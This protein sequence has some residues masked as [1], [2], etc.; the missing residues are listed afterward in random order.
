MST[1][2]C[3]LIWPDGPPTISLMDHVYQLVY[4]L[5]TYLLPLLGLSVTYTYLGRVLWRMQWQRNYLLEN[6]R[7][8]VRVKKEMRKVK[9]E[10]EK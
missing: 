3:L 9:M 10:E 6:D 4:L 5:V 7:G 8:A 1:T 2:A